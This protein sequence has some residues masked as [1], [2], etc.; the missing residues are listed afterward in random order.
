MD[1]ITKSM[2][3]NLSKF[4]KMM[5]DKGAWSD[6]VHGVTKSQTLHCNQTITTT[7]VTPS[8][9]FSILAVPIYIP[10]DNVE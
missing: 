10:T 9:L 8:I 7:M 5:M 6:A 4:Q 2:G 3:M 1:G